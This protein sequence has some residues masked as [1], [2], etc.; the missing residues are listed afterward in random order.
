MPKRTEQNLL[1]CIGKSEAA[2]KL[3]LYCDT[4]VYYKHIMKVVFWQVFPDY[5]NFDFSL[6][7]FC[8]FL[9]TLKLWI[10]QVFRKSGNPDWSHR[11]W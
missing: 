4:E 9:T 3:Y 10:L 8:T 2:V 1:V 11:D 7:F 5:T 6:D